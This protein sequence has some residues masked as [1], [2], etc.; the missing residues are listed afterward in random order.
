MVVFALAMDFAHVHLNGLDQ[1]VKHV[2][3]DFSQFA[4]DFF[5]IGSYSF[6]LFVFRP[7]KTVEHAVLLTLAPV[8]HHG[9]EQLVPYVSLFRSNKTAFL[10][11]LFS[12]AVCA[13]A[14][15]NGGSCTAPNTCTCTS[16]WTGSTCATRKFHRRSL[17]LY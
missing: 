9:Q 7:V 13:S 16:Q 8:H 1:D 4:T 15:Q 12:S 14:C 3:E 5:N 6:Q 10:S 11:S 17:T 2:C